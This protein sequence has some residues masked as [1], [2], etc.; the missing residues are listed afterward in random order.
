MDFTLSPGDLSDP[1][2]DSFNYKS[3]TGENKPRSGLFWNAVSQIRTLD[4]EL[5]PD[6]NSDHV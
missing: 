3:A 1:S 2:Q 5:W 4:G 6:V